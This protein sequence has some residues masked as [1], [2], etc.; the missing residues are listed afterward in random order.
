MTTMNLAMAILNLDTGM[1]NL[2]NKSI[3]LEGNSPLNDIHKEILKNFEVLYIGRD[4][5]QNL[6]GLPKCIK[7]IRYYMYDEY[8]YK[9]NNCHCNNNG[10]NKY[11]IYKDF[12][13]NQPINNLHIGLEYLELYGNHI[14][15]LNNL[16]ITLKY[17]LIYWRCYINLEYL[18]ESLEVL[19]LD[20]IKLT[21]I[22]QHHLPCGL[23]ELYLNGGIDTTIT[24][25]SNEL[26]ILYING[27]YSDLNKSIILPNKLQTFIFYDNEWSVENK[28]IIK[29]LFKNKQ[30][31]KG[32]QKCIFPLHYIDILY[33]LKEYTKEYINHDI[34]WKFIDIYP[35][36]I[37]EHITQ[38]Y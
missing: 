11:M 36:K 7:A 15:E 10:N 37:I 30:I 8:Y 16:P 1:L 6:A 20:Y 4:F 21:Y 17:L 32:L 24:T 35:E 23:K 25:F 34:E 13:F 27:L 9:Y 5:N 29:G 31:P 19:Y 22:S 28:K 33:L 3:L 38:I 14:Q 26:N 18:P 12:V 2:N